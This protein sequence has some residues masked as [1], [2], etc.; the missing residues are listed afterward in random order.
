ML[1]SRAGDQEQGPNQAP[2]S[3]PIAT[4]GGE[5]RIGADG[6]GLEEGAVSGLERMGFAVREDLQS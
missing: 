3:G 4:S 1:L 5:G 2:C 6:V